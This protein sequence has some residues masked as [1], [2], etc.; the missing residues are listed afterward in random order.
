MRPPLVALLDWTHLLEDFLD[1]IG[2]S[3]EQ[4]QREMTGGWLFG[5]VEALRAAGVPD[6]R[7][8]FESFSL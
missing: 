1:N 4:F 3:F 8:H 5:Y 6:R 7:L 2:V